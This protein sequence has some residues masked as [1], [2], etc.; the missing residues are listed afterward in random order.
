MNG[1]THQLIANL[2]IA[3]L[4]PKLRHILYPRWGGIE[5]GS[6]LS[7]EFRIMWEPEEANSQNRQLVHRC[8]IDSDDPK[9]HGCVTRAW[10][11]SVGS[12]GFIKDYMEGDMPG[13]YNEDEFLE[14]LGMYLGVACHHIGDLCTPV[15]VGHKIDLKR[16]GAKSLKAFHSTVERDIDRFAKRASIRLCLPRKVSLSKSYFWGIAKETYDEIF[17]ELERIYESND[18]KGKIEMTSMVISK[19]LKHTADVWHTI[20]TKSGMTDRKWSYQP[21]I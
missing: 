11:H 3:A 19:S 7:D 13:A 12:I 2:A 18:E 14:N 16:I 1:A 5:A 21:L 15:H 4:N 10:D 8:Y 9:D 20:L 6:T 17:T